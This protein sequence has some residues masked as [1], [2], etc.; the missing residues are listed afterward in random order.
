MCCS[1]VNGRTVDRCQR[2]PLEYAPSWDGISGMIA[3]EVCTPKSLH[4]LLA[5]WWR[6]L[7]SPSLTFQGENNE[8]TASITSL[9]YIANWE[10]IH[11]CTQ[12]GVEPIYFLSTKCKLKYFNAM[13][14]YRTYC[15][16]FWG[17]CVRGNGEQLKYG[18][19]S[20][21]KQRMRVNTG[22]N[23]QIRRIMCTECL[24]RGAKDHGPHEIEVDVR[25]FS[26]RVLVNSVT[27]PGARALWNFL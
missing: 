11:S 5:D 15:V 25:P 16:L 14:N 10:L 2:S 22:L 18:K 4:V 17:F 9:R 3:N 23:Q 27:N 13:D 7:H 21:S 1:H 12:L 6:D 26:G 8:G 24:V 19:G 20:I